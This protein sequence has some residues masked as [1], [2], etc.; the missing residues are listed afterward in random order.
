[1]VGDLAITELFL[2]IQNDR[3]SKTFRQLGQSFLQLLRIDGGRVLR[4]V[5]RHILQIFQID[6]GPPGIV[7]QLLQERVAQ[8]S[9]EPGPCFAGIPQLTKILLGLAEAFLRQIFR[10]GRGA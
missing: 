6:A 10:I 5:V 9:K 1:M 8:N 4:N 3:S 2:V 7:S